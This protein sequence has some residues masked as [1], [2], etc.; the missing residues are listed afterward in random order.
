MVTP[1]SFSG[2]GWRTLDSSR[3]ESLDRR[4]ECGYH[5]DMIKTIPIS[6]LRKRFGEIEQ[7][8][9]YTDRIVI[10]KKGKP[11]A[12]ISAVPSVKQE[13][14]RTF[15]GALHDTALDNDA[16]WDGVKQ[17]KSRKGPITL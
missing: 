4:I 11:F 8:L 2:V 13:R 12:S 3:D 1:P 6:E 17:K 16:L 7:A 15:A 14:M 5:R 10:T 9:P